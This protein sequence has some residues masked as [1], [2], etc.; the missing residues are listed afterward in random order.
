[1]RQA[2]EKHACTYV[3]V[4]VYLHACMYAVRAHGVRAIACVLRACVYHVGWGFLA[5]SDSNDEVF[6]HVS[7]LVGGNSLT[8]GADVLFG[9]GLDQRA[10]MLSLVSVH[11][12]C[13]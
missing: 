5:P 6:C 13:S 10:G 3:Y 8:I 1:M 11:H 7:Q 9:T 12:F 2:Y 4:H